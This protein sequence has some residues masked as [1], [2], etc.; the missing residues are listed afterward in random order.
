MGQVSN[1]CPIFVPLQGDQVE[2]GKMIQFHFCP[3]FVLT[4]CDGLR[5]PNGDKSGTILRPMMTK[6]SPEQDKTENLKTERRQKW[7]T[8]QKWDKIVTE[9]GQKQDKIW[10]VDKNETKVGIPT[11][12]RSTQKWL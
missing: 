6:S 4:I 11:L 10:T 12:T 7:D 8:G 2:N 3:V 9:T 5:G 1:F